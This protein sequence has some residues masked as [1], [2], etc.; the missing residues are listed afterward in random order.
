MLLRRISVGSASR[1]LRD[2]WELAQDQ[3]Q[4]GEGDIT[5]CVVVFN[6]G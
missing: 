5:H 6:I 4:R 1:R 2:L 3:R